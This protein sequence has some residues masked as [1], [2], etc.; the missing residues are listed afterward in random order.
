MKRNSRHPATGSPT[1]ENE[2]LSLLRINLY[3]RLRFEKRRKN[4]QLM[5]FAG[6]YYY[7]KLI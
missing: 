1:L 4:K 6:K 5:I 3:F 7:L 2:S